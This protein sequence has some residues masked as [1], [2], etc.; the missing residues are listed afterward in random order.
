MRTYHHACGRVGALSMR[1][2]AALHSPLAEVS[3]ARTDLHIVETP[4][5]E[6]V[7]RLKLRGGDGADQ[8]Q[9]IVTEFAPEGAGFDA[10][11]ASDAQW[12]PASA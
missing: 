4:P 10:Y 2:A 9:A 8:P 12:R 1:C 6:C 7:R 3:G 11:V 5:D